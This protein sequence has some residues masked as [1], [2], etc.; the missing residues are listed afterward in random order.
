[1]ARPG[2]VIGVV[3]ADWDGEVFYPTSDI[4]RRSTELTR[5]HFHTNPNVG[6][7]LRHLLTEAGF[8]RAE[9]YARAIHH[10]TADEA[11]GFGRFTAAGFRDPGTVRLSVAHGWATADELEEMSQAWLA[12]SEFPG[13]FVARF[14]CEAIAWAD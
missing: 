8:D 13:A 9:G 3:D 6:K 11:G 4:L 2:A 12:W 7:Q 10:G 14:W 1:V 5:V